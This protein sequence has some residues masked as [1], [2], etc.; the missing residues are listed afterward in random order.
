MDVSGL[1]LWGIFPALRSFNISAMAFWQCKHSFSSESKLSF[2]MGFSGCC[3]S[4]TPHQQWF[5]IQI[6]CWYQMFCR[7]QNL[8]LELHKAAETCMFHLAKFHPLMLT[9]QIPE[10]LGEWWVPHC[11]WQMTWTRL[12]AFEGATLL[13]NEILWLPVHDPSVNTITLS[14]LSSCYI[15]LAPFSFLFC[16][17]CKVMCLLQHV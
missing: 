16:C 13:W 1:L 9:P 17:E 12:R 11:G 10:N 7:P 5:L 3:P 14:D 8:P 6:Y 2:D 4:T 15:L